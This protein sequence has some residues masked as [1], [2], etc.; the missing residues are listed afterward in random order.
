M[1]CPVCPQ[2]LTYALI[3]LMDKACGPCQRQLKQMQAGF[4]GVIQESRS[5]KTIWD[6][7]SGYNEWVHQLVEQDTVRVQIKK[8]DD[9]VLQRCDT[10]DMKR[11]VG[12]PKFLPL[13][14]QVFTA[15]INEG[16]KDETIQEVLGLTYSQL[17]HVKKVIRVRL[18]KQMAYYHQI[19]KLEK[20]GKINV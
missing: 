1:Q 19:K 6:N 5:K 7:S 17:F 14:D 8:K 13:E 15:W 9:Y 16:R 12:L 4:R 11:V 2:R 3:Q 18:Q 20:E 10:R